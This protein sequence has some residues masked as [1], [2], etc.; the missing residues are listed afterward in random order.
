[1]INK[2]IF[3]SIKNKF[4]IGLCTIALIGFGIYSMTKVPLGAVPDI[5][6]NQ[7][8]VITTSPNLGTTDIEQFVTYP[9]ELAMANLP[10][11]IEIRSIS[12]FGLS[13]VTIVF[14]EDLGTYLPRQLV[15][16][17]LNEVEE[18][19]PEKFGSPSMG[20]ISTGLGEIYQYYLTVDPEYDSVYT[21]RKLRTIQDWIIKRQMAMLPGIV[22]VNSFGGHIKQYEVALNP[23]RLKSMDITIA[24]VYHAIE[25]NNGNTGGAYIEKNHQ[26]NFIRGE[27]LVGSLD[28]IRNIVIKTV[29]GIPI[30]VS[31]VA[32]VQLGS[33]VRYGAFTKDGEGEA[34]G[35]IVM[36]LKNANPNEVI[37]RVKDRM[38]QIQKSL[39]PGVHI[40]PFLDRSE[41]IGRTT[42]TVSKNLIEGALIVIFVLVLLLGNL[43]GGLIVASVIPLSLLFA[44]IMMHIFKVHA[45]LMSL[46]AIDFGILVDGAVIVV[47]GV[48]HLMDKYILKHPDKRLTTGKMDE[49]T[50]TSGS[51]MMN[52]AFFGQLII[53]IVF[54]PILSLTGV[55]GK[56]FRPMALTFS[57]AVTGAMILCLTYVPMVSALFLGRRS[58]RKKK[59]N[60]FETLSQKIISGIERVY[61]PVIHWALKRWKWVL[62]LAVL[63]LVLAGFTFTRMGA[64]FIPNLDEG[65]IVMHA[66]LKP[67]SSLSETIEVT[68]KAEKILLDKFPEINHVVARMGVSEIPT[69]PMPMDFADM[70]IL[71]KPKEEWTSAS[72]KE[73]LIKKIKQ[74][75][76][77]LPGVNYQFTQPIE[78]RFNELMTGVREDIAIKIYGDDLEVLAQKAKALAGIIQNVDGIGDLKV[79]ATRG[80][81]QMTIDYDRE[82]LAQYGLNIEDLN[83]VVETAF[84][85]KKAGQVFEGE[86]RFDIVLRMGKEHRQGI[87]D[88]KNLYVLTPMGNKIPLKEVADISYQPGPMQISR[89]GTKRR[90]YVGINIRGRDVESLVNE[91]QQKLDAQ[92]QL[93]PGYYV[94]Y[95]G[96]F[97]NLQRAKQRLGIV[98]PI[99]LILIFLLLYFALNSFKQSAMIYVAIPLAAIGGIF[100]LYFRGIPFSIS[101]GVGFIVLFGVAVLNGLVLINSLNELKQQGISD[102][103]ERIYKGTKQRLRPILLTA[104]SAIMGFTPMALSTSAGAEVQRPLAT[105]VIGGLITATLLTLIVIP[106]LYYLMERKH[107]GSNNEKQGTLPVGVVSVLALLLFSGLSLIPQRSLAQKTVVSDTLVVSSLQEAT[108]IAMKNNPVTQ[109]ATLKVTKH[110]QLQKTAVDLPKTSVYYGREETNSNIPGIQSMGISQEFAFPTVYGK[111]SAFLKSKTLLA[112]KARGITVNQLR[113]KIRLAYYHLQNAYKSRDVYTKLDSFYHGFYEAAA[114]RFKTGET[115]KLEMMAAKGQKAEIKLQKEQSKSNVQIYLQQLQRLL[116]VEKPVMVAKREKVKAQM[117]ISVADTALLKAT[118]LAQYQQQQIAVAKAKLRVEKSMLLPSINA[119]YALQKVNGQTGFHSFQIGIGIPLWFRP[120][121]GRIQAAKTSLSIQQKQ[122]EW[123]QLQRISN[124]KQLMKKFRLVNASLNYYETQGKQIADEI[125]RSNDL[126]FRKGEIGYVEYLQNVNNAIDLKGDYLNY[127]NQYNEVV[128]EIKYLLN[129]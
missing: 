80:L 108:N 19:I 27:G 65:D 85:G 105:V 71:L 119:G 101:A 38:V 50:F 107:T 18:E 1:M 75:V 78:M 122:K 10:G 14:E 120:Q 111:K 58:K 36:M 23:G 118:A 74:S 62:S 70:F 129:E 2:I 4:I 87:N 28:D 81:P 95:G 48:V 54:L 109:I 89:D 26:A 97:K 86:R 64:V 116:H 12:R 126:A 63:F 45:N 43:R 61:S 11:V 99:A 35:G 51:K 53:L 24:E 56:M 123:R 67:G 40:E 84:A 66:L 93:P 39:P 60:I 121:Q 91:I 82:K 13:V 128:I 6:N 110:R 88:I 22:E 69:D 114:L 77:V 25:K 8:Q 124:F 29:N 20:P 106:V 102:I 104:V 7:V 3:F 96:E 44:F 115:N 33:A 100:S 41:L 49:L 72:T 94:T 117:P 90:I 42:N 32:K 92:L 52:S 31:D 76:S 46:G 55:E 30:L 59:K 73:E 103:K 16:E 112:E 47:E 37:Q 68:N 5:T 79:E 34:V 125:L 9:V 113:R 57:F 98:V 127:L 21:D 15:A 17:K 83:T